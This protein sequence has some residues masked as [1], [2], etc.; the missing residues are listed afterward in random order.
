LRKPDHDFPVGIFPDLTQRC[1][2]VVTDDFTQGQDRLTV[3]LRFVLRNG[4]TTLDSETLTQDELFTAGPH[5]LITIVRTLRR[6]FVGTD[7]LALWPVGE[8]PRFKFER[9]DIRIGGSLLTDDK[10]P[11]ELEEQKEFDSW[12]KFLEWLPE[13]EIEANVEDIREF[14]KAEPREQDEFL[15]PPKFAVLW[16]SGAEEP[17]MGRLAD[18]LA[19]RPAFAFVDGAGLRSGASPR[20]E[21]QIAVVSEGLNRLARAVCEWASGFSSGE[22]SAWKLWA[23]RDESGKCDDLGSAMMLME[24][25]EQPAQEWIQRQYEAVMEFRDMRWFSGALATA[26]VETIGMIVWK[27]EWKALMLMPEEFQKRWKTN[28]DEL[29]RLTR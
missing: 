11:E 1:T 15:S 5:R 7:V 14:L 10:W 16:I 18:E 25:L 2:V 20:L 9:F 4:G 8:V 27:R 23:I 19:G 13:L 22:L 12:E 28:V 6:V 3:S 21:K 24:K 26:I 29:R 17:F